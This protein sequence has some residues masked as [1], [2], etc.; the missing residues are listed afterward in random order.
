MLK[1]NEKPMQYINELWESLA[2]H[3]VLPS[4]TVIL[5]STSIHDNGILVTWLVPTGNTLDLVKNTHTD[6]KFFQEHSILWAK[7][8]DDYLYELKEEGTLQNC[9]VSYLL[10]SC[11]VNFRGVGALFV[12]PSVSSSYQ[13]WR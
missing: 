6:A 5:D 2:F 8:N 10:Y 3:F 7:V 11:L 12:A 4:H 13:D 1:V 9:L